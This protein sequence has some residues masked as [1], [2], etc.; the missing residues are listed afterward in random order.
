MQK[1]S[2]AWF[3]S[4]VQIGSML[5]FAL[6]AAYVNWACD[7][8][9]SHSSRQVELQGVRSYQAASSV[10]VNYHDFS[11]EDSL[12][13]DKDL[14]YLKNLVENHL[15]FGLQIPTAPGANET[16]VLSGTHDVSLSYG[17]WVNRKDIS[18]PMQPDPARAAE[19]QELFP[20]DADSQ[21]QVL[22]PAPGEWI[23][24]FP[25]ATQVISNVF[26]QLHYTIDF[27][28][29]GACNGCMIR[30]TS[31]TSVNPFM[32]N[33]LGRLLGKAMKTSP[34]GLTCRTPA[35][36]FVNLSEIDNQ[37]GEITYP[38]GPLVAAFGFYGGPLYAQTSSATVVITAPLQHTDSLTRTFNLAPIKSLRGW[39]YQWRDLNDQPITQVQVV[40]RPRSIYE[41]RLTQVRVFG[42]G[43]PIC[44]AQQDTIWLTA[45][46]ASMP[47]VQARLTT[48]VDV[49][50]QSTDC[51]LADWGV[52]M[53]AACSP[54]TT[55]CS[56]L[57][58]GGWV[59]YT[60]AITNF[61]EVARS[62]AVTNTLPLEWSAV[63]IPASCTRN[64]GRNSGVVSCAVSN[65]SPGGSRSLSIAVQASP[66]YSGTLTN[67]VEVQPAG[68]ADPR[69]YDNTAA[70]SVQVVGPTERRLY[71]PAILRK[72]AL[73]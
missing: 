56:Q 43:L 38:D 45:T 17:A 51:T 31:C 42:S 73:P 23:T 52:S 3:R 30:L 53:E 29:T 20:A 14:T 36:T 59:T 66:A 67:R 55:H 61:D 69:Q 13:T 2:A 27:K 49:I 68:A 63:R 15:I 57:N 8:G 39:N 34:G 32:D 72:P 1:S 50:P 65:L 44:A 21:W 24:Q 7:Y 54:S 60:L 62:G 10:L 46:M 58:P 41:Y 9:S 28:S 16:G 47:S 4:F 37:T 5:L 71:L 35:P 40:P 33:A 64:S 26:G 48:Q 19:I 70:H 12:R 11:I 22:V 6:A 18:I 25:T